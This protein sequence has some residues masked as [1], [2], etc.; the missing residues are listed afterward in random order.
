[1]TIDLPVTQGEACALKPRDYTSDVKPI[2]CPGCGD[3]GV[4]AAITRT[5]SALAL[6]KEDVSVVSGIGCSSRLPAYLS[7]Y[8]FH[9][10]HGRAL[11]AAT[12]IALTRPDLTVLVVGGDGDGFSIGGNHFVHACRRNVDLT[13]LV[14]DNRVYGMT[15]GQASPTSEGTLRTALTPAGSQL[16]PFD[17]LFVARSFS[18]DPAQLSEVLAAAIRHRGFAFVQVLS[19]CVTFRPEQRE[20]RHEVERR[21]IEPSEDRREAL[22]RLLDTSALATGVLFQGQRPVPEAASHEGVDE[23]AALAALEEPLRISDG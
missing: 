2:W 21:A 13:Y 10:L 14:M 16:D 20:W 8:G 5:L 11:P 19:P 12:G 1:M 6:P 23:A 7:T 17:P 22:L 9:G 4:L 18:G 3:Y 15:K